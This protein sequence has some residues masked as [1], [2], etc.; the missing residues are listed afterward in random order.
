MKRKTLDMLLVCALTMAITTF[1]AS[2]ATLAAEDSK[3]EESSAVLESAEETT[4]EESLLSVVGVYYGDIYANQTGTCYSDQSLDGFSDCIIV[5]DYANDAKNRTLP[6]SSL[7]PGAIWSSGFTCPEVT[8]SVN[9]T[10]TYEAYDPNGY[11]HHYSNAINRYTPYS[12]PIGYGNLLG[13]A[14]PVRM[15]SVF[16]VNPNELK[17]DTNAVLT[18]ADQSVTF[19]FTN[20]HQ[21]TYPDEIRFQHC[22]FLYRYG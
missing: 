9:D 22:H 7:E 14:D 13:G 6:A 21:I 1:G 2:E 10:N 17:A 11:F 20:I 4:E 3:A 5:F 18:V 8:L 16:Y 12:N 15:Y 19:D